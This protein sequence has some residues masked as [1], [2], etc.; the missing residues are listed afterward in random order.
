[1]P[2]GRFMVNCGGI[3]GVSDMTYGA[4][5]PKSMNDVWMHNSAIRALSEAFPGKVSW[6]RMPE[7]NGEN[8]LALTGLLPDLSSWSSAVPGHLSETVK[9]WK[10]CAPS[11]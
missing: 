6:K 5:R 4:A 1:M 8:F 10:P 11:Q 9:K 2:N 3:D 7:R